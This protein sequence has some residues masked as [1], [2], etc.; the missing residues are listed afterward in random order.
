MET[1]EHTE[2]YEAP[3]LTSFGTIEA[4]TQGRAGASQIGIS[5]SISGEVIVDVEI[6]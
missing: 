5:V 4:W 3:E 2:A 1:N 6:G